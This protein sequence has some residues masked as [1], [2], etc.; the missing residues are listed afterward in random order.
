MVIICEKVLCFPNVAA[1]TISPCA[2][3]YV[4]KLVINSSLATTTTTGHAGIKSKSTNEISVAITSSLSAIGS[5]IVPNAVISFLILAI[6]PSKKS[7]KAAS[8]NTNKAQY[9]AKYYADITLS[10][11]TDKTIRK[12]VREFAGFIV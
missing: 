8:E 3:Q 2:R 10:I 1:G 12:I 11:S 6:L 7:V 5:I 9:F 4:L